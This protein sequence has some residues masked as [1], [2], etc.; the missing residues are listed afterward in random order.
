MKREL[1]EIHFKKY[2]ELY[3]YSNEDQPLYKKIKNESRDS[4]IDLSLGSEN[5]IN[6]LLFD[7][8]LDNDMKVEISQKFFNKETN[9]TSKMINDDSNIT[10]I[11]KILDYYDAHLKKLKYNF[12]IY[13]FG[14]IIPINVSMKMQNASR[15]IPRHLSISYTI[16]LYNQKIERQ[17]LFY[18]ADLLKLRENNR[19]IYFYDIMMSLNLMKQTYDLNQYEAEIN[20][21]IRLNQKSGTQFLIQ[22]IGF[23]F[24]N[25]SRF[26][27]Q[28]SVLNFENNKVK[29]NVIIEP[30]LE[31]ENNYNKDL[32]PITFPY[33]RV[34]SLFY[35]RFIY[36]HVNDLIPYKYDKT[37]FSKLIISKK[38]KEILSTIFETDSKDY[39]GDFIQNKHGGLVILAEGPTG[40]GKTSTAEVYSELKEK[41]LYVVQIQELGTTATNIEQNLRI[42]F[43]RVQKWNAVLLFDEID[44]F[45]FKRENDLDQS[46]VVGIFLRLLDY[47]SGLIFFTTNR[48][49]VLDPAILSRISLNIKYPSLDEQ[50]RLMIWQ[51]LLKNAS[52]KINQLEILPKIQLN[53]R[54][55]KN[56]IRLSKI[57]YGKDLKEEKVKELID[58]YLV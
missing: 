56:A 11:D 25:S 4:T 2:L 43:E 51:E 38:T 9:E 47:F 32:E 35:K 53:G 16:R 27:P 23:Y 52:L 33:L 58:D 26:N 41:P 39:Y 40:V 8:E 7:S 45:L 46:A 6:F 17:S 54:Q 57:I 28:V 48:K 22:K 30:N 5:F 34:F 31:I 49:E 10:G 15:G 14:K 19:K 50:S 36:V 18:H 44:I 1:L 3:H 21:T 42:I 24:D 20:H 37:S 12:D 13:F 29:S 55:I